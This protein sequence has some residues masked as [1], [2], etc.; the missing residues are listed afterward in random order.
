MTAEEYEA[1]FLRRKVSFEPWHQKTPE[2]LNEQG[3]IQSILERRCGAQFGKDCYISPDAHVATDK[4]TMGDRTIVA[5]R[6]IIRGYV[7][8][9][10]DCSVNP[11][12]HIA[13]L[14]EIGSAVRIAPN[15]GIYGFSHGFEKIDIPIKDQPCTIKGI[16]I[17]D[18]VWIGANAVILDGAKIGAH[19]IVGAGA[20]VTGEFPP[21]QLI[22]GNPARI[23][24]DRRNAALMPILIEFQEKIKTQIPEIVA[25]CVRKNDLNEIWI[26]DEIGQ[27]RKVRPWCDAIELCAMFDLDFP[28]YSRDEL[29]KVLK[30]FQEPDNGIVAEWM[31]SDSQYMKPNHDYRLYDTMIVNY[32]LECLGSHL[33]Y[34]VSSVCISSDALVKRL[35]ALSWKE[36]AW[37]AGDWVDCFG[38]CI[39]INKAYFAETEIL[40]KYFAQTSII[41]S[42]FY[43]LD[44]VCDSKTGVWGEWSTS[45]RW[46][47]PINGFY[48]LTRGTYAQ[49]GHPLPYPKATIDTLLMHSEDEAYF[50]FNETAHWHVCNVLDIVHPFWLCLKQ[51]DYRRQDI[52]RWVRD[53]LP[54]I[55]KSWIENRGFSIEL[56]KS[57]PSLQGTEMWLTVIWLMADILA[58]SKTLTFNPQ[59][60]HRTHSALK[61]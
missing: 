55:M 49:F 19:S 43:W 56:G 27:S 36:Y 5:A 31:P 12:A 46:L 61:V 53:R 33:S 40:E 20:V 60:V 13:G 38:S 57:N 45:M 48:R 25:S 15:V 6:S 34:P 35:N 28:E 29:I 10:S 3:A 42:L 30:S 26:S 17:G 32:A 9:G 44:Q 51:V 18:D 16:V 58:V 52:E 54:M 23:L 22:G 24:K 59:G 39:Y 11:H 41:E 4:L 50:G 14:V 47:Q 8:I 1:E 37:S 2:I 7:K 21:Y